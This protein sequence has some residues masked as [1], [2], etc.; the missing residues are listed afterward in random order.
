M[1][2]KVIGATRNVAIVGPYLS[3]KTALL[4]S[5]LSVTG[6]ITRKGNVK[7]G[8]TI[9]DSSPEA[10]DRQMS[11]EVNAATAEYEGVRFTFL[12]C[13][14]SVE[15]AQETYNALIGVDAAIIVCEPVADRTLTL[16]PLFK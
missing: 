4:E 15:F 13:P 3:G 14:G 7:E 10:R 2:E 5:L 12:D 1:N 6:T 16:A 11:V 9:G 8:N